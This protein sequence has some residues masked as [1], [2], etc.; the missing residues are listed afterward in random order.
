M[1]RVRAS[2]QLAATPVNA[3]RPGLGWRQSA[4]R[5]DPRGATQEQVERHRP[6]RRR[7]HGAARRVVLR[8]RGAVKSR[9]IRPVAKTAFRSRRVSPRRRRRV[10]PVIP[11]SRMMRSAFFR[12]TTAPRRRS[13]ACTLGTPYAP[14]EAAWTRVIS[15]ASSSSARSSARRGPPGQPRVVGRAVHTEG[16]AQQC[17]SE[18]GLLR[19]K[20]PVERVYRLSWAKK[21]AAEM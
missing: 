7:R 18:L 14:R 2:G 16:P 10:I 13:S 20:E 15:A 5:R 21:A 19:V 6:T 4:D 3:R 1:R 17:R 8:G 12:L 11:R 9:P